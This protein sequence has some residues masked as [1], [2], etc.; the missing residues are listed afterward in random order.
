MK[1]KFLASQNF[2][3]LRSNQDILVLVPPLANGFYIRHCKTPSPSLSLLRVGGSEGDSVCAKRKN[4]FPNG[5]LQ[6]LWCESTPNRILLHTNNA[7]WSEFAFVAGKP[8]LPPTFTEW[9]S[10]IVPRVFNEFSSCQSCCLVMTIS[11]SLRDDKWLECVFIELRKTPVKKG[12][13]Y[14][15][16]KEFQFTLR[17][18][19]YL[20]RLAKIHLYS[21]EQC[22]CR[23]SRD[24]LCKEHFVLLQVENR[25]IRY[26]IKRSEI[27][28]KC[29]YELS[30]PVNI[31]CVTYPGPDRPR[32]HGSFTLSRDK[33][34]VGFLTSYAY[35]DVT[36]HV[37]NLESGT[38]QKRELK[39]DSYSI[40]SL[41]FFAVG[42]LYSVFDMLVYDR[43]KFKTK[44]EVVVLQTETGK[45]IVS[46]R[47]TPVVY[48]GCN[49]EWMSSLAA[50]E[51]PRLFKFLL[52]DQSGSIYQSLECF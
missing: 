1:R 46:D 9:D 8:H 37:W 36:F 10:V 45:I 21:V 12:Y 20:T 13:R 42:S 18:S 44:K 16:T 28:K 24:P 31:M 51:E 32:I 47:M 29:N 15:A 23:N 17:G 3:T 43:R 33:K 7:T 14:A 50:L 40:H 19:D 41:D 39:L 27:S 2:T 30:D 48:C 25:I 22:A 5:M 35:M 11:K 49:E 34:L 4:I 6:I 52:L 26:R 38:Y